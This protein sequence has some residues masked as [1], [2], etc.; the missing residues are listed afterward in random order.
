MKTHRERYSCELTSQI[1]GKF[2]CSFL[3]LSLLLQDIFVT[4]LTL[5]WL[6]WSTKEMLL[7]SASYFFNK[8]KIVFP[9]EITDV[10]LKTN[11]FLKGLSQAC[12]WELLLS[13]EHSWNRTTSRSHCYE[14]FTC[15]LSAT[16]CFPQPAITICK[17]RHFSHVKPVGISVQGLT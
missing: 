9:S 7:T 4:I 14:A 16:M 5:Q 1:W 8:K 2:C 11:L 12:L 6:Q 13:A 10:A 3:S 15:L 17:T